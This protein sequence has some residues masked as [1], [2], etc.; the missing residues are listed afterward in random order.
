MS[1]HSN[2]NKRTKRNKMKNRRR[3]VRVSKMGSRRMRVGFRDRRPR[4]RRRTR[5]RTSC[6][7]Y[8][9]RMLNKINICLERV[10]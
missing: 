9:R 5:R 8:Y 6:D 3:K 1:R 7:L 4:K 10:F 2:S